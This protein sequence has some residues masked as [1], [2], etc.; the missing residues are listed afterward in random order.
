MISKTGTAHALDRITRITP[1][2]GGTGCVF[3]LDRAVPECPVLCGH[4]EVAE[5]G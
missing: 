4:W 3:P 1:I 5:M 2:P